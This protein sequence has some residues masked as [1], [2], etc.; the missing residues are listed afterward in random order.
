[1]IFAYLIGHTRTTAWARDFESC[2]RCVCVVCMCIQ[3]C[4]KMACGNGATP[5]KN[6]SGIGPR[7]QNEIKSK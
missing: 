1:M 3:V 7:I 5:K 4:M 6:V 2:A